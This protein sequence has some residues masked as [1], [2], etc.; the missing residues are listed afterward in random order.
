MTLGSGDSG[1]IGYWMTGRKGFD[2]VEI[3]GVAVFGVDGTGLDAIAENLF[4]CC[5]HCRGGFARADYAQ[6]RNRIE[7]YMA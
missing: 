6:C 4:G 5:G 2:P 7:S 3:K 1:F